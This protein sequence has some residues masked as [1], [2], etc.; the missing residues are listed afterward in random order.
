MLWNQNTDSAIHWSDQDKIN[1]YPRPAKMP[2]NVSNL[3]L[4]VQ[5][6][7]NDEDWAWSLDKEIEDKFSGELN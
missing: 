2:S 3:S 7:R 6:K 5:W 4:Q 1:N